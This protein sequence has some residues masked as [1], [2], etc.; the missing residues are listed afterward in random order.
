MG[1]G[2]S[3]PSAGFR[4]D[5]CRGGTSFVEDLAVEIIGEIGQSE[6][7]LGPLHANSAHE[8]PKTVF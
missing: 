1:W 4:A 3:Q 7:R 8:Q 6:F 2:I 5:P